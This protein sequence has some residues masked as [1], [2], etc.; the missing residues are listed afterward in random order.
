MP[1]G[2]LSSNIPDLAA[3]ISVNKGV[4]PPV[5][6]TTAEAKEGG[7]QSD[8]YSHLSLARLSATQEQDLLKTTAVNNA[9]RL[10]EIED[11]P[12]HSG[13]DSSKNNDGNKLLEHAKSDRKI[14]KSIGLIQV[15]IKDLTAQGKLGEAAAHLPEL[16]ELAAQLVDGENGKI[17]VEKITKEIQ[18]AMLDKYKQHFEQPKIRE[19]IAKLIEQGLVTEADLKK[20]AEAK[21]DTT[22]KRLISQVLKQILNNPKADPALKKDIEAILKDL[23]AKGVKDPS[24]G[25]VLDAMSRS[26]NS[27]R[28][29]IGERNLLALYR[30]HVNASL[31][32][33]EKERKQV[34]KMRDD[35]VKQA[36]KEVA[37]QNRN[38]SESSKREQLKKYIMASTG[39]R[40]EKLLEAFLRKGHIGRED[41][42]EEYGG[43]MK[44]LE[45]SMMGDSH[46]PMGLALHIAQ[47]T[48]LARGHEFPDNPTVASLYDLCKKPA[49]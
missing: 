28:D 49:F 23:E 27:L 14:R 41:L 26:N 47:E 29:L 43:V 1:G 48:A 13:L 10:V 5:L 3:S 21:D 39:I 36:L 22:K 34:S 32:D 18:A 25:H 45:M 42:L 30:T 35:E 24:A 19:A 7:N 20:I 16:Q 12:S 9:N 46:I 6:K 8:S 37:I 33:F 17:V 44:L 15:Q 31:D 38:Q 11:S 40:S 2:Q 4:Q